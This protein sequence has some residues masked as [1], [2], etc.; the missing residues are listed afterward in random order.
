[1]KNRLFH[2]ILVLIIILS[3]GSGCALF[4]VLFQIKEEKFAQELASDGMEAYQEGKYKDA[5]ES[6]EKIKDWYPFSKYAILAELKIADSHYKLKEYE[7]AVSAYEQFENLHPL[8]DA[9][10][11]IIF[12]T[13]L[14]YFEQVD[15]SDR[16]QTRARKALESFNRLIKQFPNSTYSAKAREYI[17]K[18]YKSLAESELEI[19]IFY[20]KSK[21]YKA[22]L[23]RFKSLVI[24]YPDV[25]V[26]QKA[27]QY[28]ALCETLLSKQK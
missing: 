22:A 26:H 1:M 6:F 12:Q 4:N 7:E 15:T 14:C 17:A 2:L 16:D 5:I 18:C 23:E 20:Y 27:L 9:I 3:T 11:Y 10:P 24:N 25:G 8:N 28:I 19:G 13:G 21:H